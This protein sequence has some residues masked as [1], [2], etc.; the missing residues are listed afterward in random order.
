[1]RWRHPERLIRPSHGLTLVAALLACSEERA[2]RAPG[3]ESPANTGRAV[4]TRDAKNPMALAVTPERDVYFI[5]RTGEVRLYSAQ[6]GVVSTAAVLD[7]DTSHEGGL[8]GLTLDPDF[9]RNHL[10]YLY[11]SSPLSAE[12]EPLVPPGENLLVRLRTL[13]DG[14]LDLESATVL[15]R[16]PSERRC[17]HEGGALAFAADGTLFLSTGDNTNP[18]ESDGRA[19]LDGRVGR[20]T[21][22]SRRTSGNP[23]DLRGKIL[24]IRSDGTIPEGNL[25]PPSGE[26]GRPEVYALGVRNPF[27]L[28]ADAVT[29][30]LFFGDIGPDGVE[31]GPRGPRGYD[32]LD[33]ADAPSDFGWPYCIADNVPYPAVDFATSAVGEPFDCSTRQGSVFAYDYSTLSHEA[34][35]T[36]F[37]DDGVFLGRMLVA[38]AVYRS[39]PAAPFALPDE[40]E[41]SVLLAE[42]TRDR[43]LAARVDGAG[44]LE[45]LGRL[46]AGETFHRPI[47]IEIGPDGAI[48]VLEYGSSFWGDNPDAALSRFEY[49]SRL[50]PSAVLAASA[51]TGA[52]PLGVRFSG[53][54]SRAF[55]V[56]ETLVRYDWDFDADGGA[57]A[58]GV[59][60]E[61]VFDHAG[62]YAVGLRVVSSSGAISEPVSTRIVV[63][64]SPPTVRILTPALGTVLFSGGEY[65]LTGEGFD[66]EDGAAPCEELVWTIS[67]GHNAHAHP[68]ETL[69]GCSAAFVPDTA[70]HGVSGEYLFY[71]V[72]L[73]YTD[74]GGP[75]GEPALT[76][77]KGI[78][79]EVR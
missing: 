2:E 71:A 73:S 49:G 22:D 12:P 68:T 67:L 40:Y 24:R 75:G 72:E 79:L 13:P 65:L 3:A 74:H 42:W 8:L 27:R 64:N 15:L 14:S 10:L 46:L 66:A 58:H 35:G 50:S 77:R 62:E 60:V 70:N 7:V 4:L 44:R 43:L 6:T 9:A 53:A 59:E 61:H 28:A 5:E 51:T 16:V 78:R 69:T 25:F 45:H 33:V 32:E 63:G 19:P 30:R 55:G 36:G 34:L 57:D 54:Q 41:G 26:L 48:Y 23:F 47:D 21:F 18:F 76:A 39:E 38:G 1:M 11:Y 20:E 56:D 17:C 31:D 37:T 29:G 52:A